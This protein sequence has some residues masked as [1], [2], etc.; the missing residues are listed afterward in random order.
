MDL[1]GKLEAP[2]V[3]DEPAGMNSSVF[4]VVKQREVF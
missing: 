3:V 4:W 1:I 2:G